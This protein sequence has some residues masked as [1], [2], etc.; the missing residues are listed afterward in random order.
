MNEILRIR[1]ERGVWSL[2]EAPG[3]QEERAAEGSKAVI[4]DSFASGRL[5]REFIKTLCPRWVHGQ[6]VR[7]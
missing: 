5:L 1:S 7:V 6:R 4:I 2:D 3:W